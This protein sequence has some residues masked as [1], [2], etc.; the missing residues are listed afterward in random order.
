ML[1][2]NHQLQNIKYIKISNYYDEPLFI[3]SQ[4]TNHSYLFLAT[5]QDSVYLITPLNNR[6]PK[7][8]KFDKNDKH[9]EIIGGKINE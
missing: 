7:F 3:I 5:S 6:L 2:T 1:P 9:F 4:T 8:D